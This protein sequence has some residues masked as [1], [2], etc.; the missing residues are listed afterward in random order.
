MKNAFFYL[1]RFYFLPILLVGVTGVSC[2][3]NPGTGATSGEMKMKSVWVAEHLAKPDSKLPFSFQYGG[4]PSSALLKNWPV[5]TET[6]QQDQYRSQTTRCWTDPETGLEVRCVSVEYSDYPVIEWTV[7]FRNIGSGKSHIISDIQGLDVQFNQHGDGG[8]VLNGNKGDWSVAESFEPFQ[9][10]LE[11]NTTTRFSP[12][13]G[14]PTNGPG[15]WPYYNLQIPGGG[16]ILAIGWPGQW[17]SSFIRDDRDGLRI[18]AG[19]ELTNLWLKPGEEIRT[20]LMVFDFW[21]GTDVDRAQNLWRRW[22]TEHNLP[23]TADK[24][25]PVPMYIYCSG[26]FFPGLCV[27]EASEKQFIDSLA[28]QNIKIDYWWMDAGWYPCDGNWGRTGTWEPD[29]T[30]FPNG[31]KA[32]SDYVHAAG[33]KLILWM[34]PERVGDNQSWLALNHPEWLLGGTLL[35][36][37]NTEATNWLTNHV[38]SLITGQGIDLYRQDYNIDPL[39]YWNANDPADRQGLTENLYVQGYLKYWDQLRHRHPG[40]L[41]DACASGGRRNDLET[42]RRAVPLLRSDYQAFDGDIGLAI[43]NQGHT[44]GLSSWLPFYGQGV[45]QNDGHMPYYVRSHMSPSFGICVDVRK[46]GINWDE[47]RRLADQWRKVADCMLGDYY[48]LTPYSL[49]PDQW[50]AWQFCRPAEGDGMVQVFRRDDCQETAK[51][52]FLKNLKS[53]ARYEIINFD[54]EGKTTV[55]GKELMGKGLPVVI[56]EKPGSAL[57]SFR[58]VH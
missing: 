23:R 16:V 33:M 48:P 28:K 38:D 55:S 1:I 11:P 26:G 15:G 14:R 3:K 42:M 22:M 21:K 47:Y 41:I 29:K 12:S 54:A 19:Q 32:V 52:F 39:N 4:K 9:K 27:S 43:G 49:Q 2:I 30:R 6:V 7:F 8:Y 25:P 40:M 58:E 46:P 50:I 56:T 24:K 37:G 57:I 17:A 20:P 51:T 5:K 13:G 35:N 18:M 53:D 45:Y 36:M 44:Y 31:I 34:E 10:P